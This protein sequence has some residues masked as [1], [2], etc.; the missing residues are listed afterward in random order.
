MP[1]VVMRDLVRQYECRAFVGREALQQA[2]RDVDVPAGE[3][4]RIAP[5]QPEDDGFDRLGIHALGVEPS[6]DA[7]DAFR[8]PG[9]GLGGVFA[10]ELRVQP[11][12]ELESRIEGVFAQIVPRW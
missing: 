8:R 9:L 3:G 2:T 12:S 4:E 1:A 11:L 10:N 6:H 7:R 5:R